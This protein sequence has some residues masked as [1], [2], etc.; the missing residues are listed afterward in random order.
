MPFPG[1]AR[2]V[3]AGRWPA[4]R[5]ERATARA[6]APFGDRRRRP[7]DLLAAG[8]PLSPS[9]ITAQSSIAVSAVAG[10]EAGLL[11]PRASAG[12]SPREHGLGGDR[13]RAG[14]KRRARASGGSPGFAGGLYDPDTGL[15]RF[16]ARDY[17]AEVGRW[18][19]KDPLRFQ[20]ADGPNLYL[21]VGGDPVNF[22][23]PRG[24]YG[25]DGGGEGGPGSFEPEEPGDDGGSQ[26]CEDP[27][28]GC[29]SGL[30]GLLLALFGG[31]IGCSPPQPECNPGPAR[32]EACD[33][34]EKKCQWSCD[35]LRSGR[36]RAECL[37]C[38]ESVKAGCQACD[39]NAGRSDRCN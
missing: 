15:V 14:A 12:I 9:S 35:S 21:Y 3:R 34:A 10:R 26:T 6:F 18:T 20:Q 19:A 17:D 30:S 28:D 7:R 38:C 5:P 32:D 36:T 27:D 2:E 4:N 33:N 39:P 11:R 22:R 23:D 24:L 13:P 31:G 29:G 25:D 37:T 16:G 1:A 8:A